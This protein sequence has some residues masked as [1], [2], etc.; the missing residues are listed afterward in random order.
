MGLFRKNL[1]D[2]KA[3]V[4]KGD[5]LTA[6]EVVKDH[7]IK[8]SSEEFNGIL[9]RLNIWTGEYNAALIKMYNYLRKG[10]RDSSKFPQGPFDAEMV[11][12]EKALGKIKR[13]IKRLIDTE[14]IKLE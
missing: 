6:L 13:D 4:K 8:H 14:R 2:A 9:Y 3:Y 12:A 7:L 11:K 5:L 10:A 1:R